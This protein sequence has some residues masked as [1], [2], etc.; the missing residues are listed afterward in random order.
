MYARSGGKREG[1]YLWLFDEPGV[2][3]HP[4]GQFDLMQALEAL[5]KTSQV[6]YATHSVFLINRNFPARHRLVVKRAQGTGLDAKPFVSRWSAAL[7]ALGFS[8]SGTLLFAPCVVLA[9]GDS[10]PLLIYPLLQKLAEAGI[11]DRDI[12]ALSVMASGDLRN[13]EAIA[14]LLLEGAHKPRIAILVDGD[15]GGLARARG[16]SAL[17]DEKQVTV[18]TLPSGRETEDYIP[19]KVA[20]IRAVAE[21]AAYVAKTDAAPVISELERRYRAWSVTP[22]GGVAVG[23]WAGEQAKEVAGLEEAPS[24][25]VV[26]RA[27]A[28]EIVNAPADGLD[29]TEGLRLAE[30]ISDAV[31]LPARATEGGLF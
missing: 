15:K 25:V 13:A 18:I 7:D 10:D 27:W 30:W 29:L 1:L 20:Y 31:K 26:A 6:V 23:R 9:E 12:N 16:L 2:W 22:E 3:L 4:A 11:W 24:K 21:T 14:R 8:I 5:A 17:A 28:Q 19:D